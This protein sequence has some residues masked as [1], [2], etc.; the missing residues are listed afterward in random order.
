MAE[1]A[2]LFEQLS[3][4]SYRRGKQF[5]KICKWF[6]ENDPVYSRE[7][8]QVW[9]WD[10]WPGQWGPDKGIDLVAEDFNGKIWAI[11]A[12]AYSVNHN[13]TKSDVNKFLSESSRSVISY[14]LL[15]STSAGMGVNAAEVI[16]GQE[17]GVGYL[18]VADL[19][20]R[21]L[22]WPEL[23]DSLV[24]TQ[25]SPPELR[26]DQVQ[27]VQDVLSGFEKNDRGQL[28]RACG[29]GKTRIGIEVS[30]AV[31]SDLT[32]VALPSLSLLAQAIRDWLSHASGDFIFLPVCSDET[33]G[34]EDQMISQVSE[35][36]MPSTNKVDGAASST[37]PAF[38][39]VWTG[40]F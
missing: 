5:E 40:A 12:K 18:F 32:L 11:Q 9:L 6:L 7:L 27:A 36:S 31:R 23:P 39:A 13:V 17:K 15:I 35:I 2:T 22:V 10:N 30:D 20:N 16:H 3:G 37:G 33:V 34:K 1:F 28:I 29:T 14:R 24:A 38:Y 25:N 8:R 26:A 19:K 21:D 4:N